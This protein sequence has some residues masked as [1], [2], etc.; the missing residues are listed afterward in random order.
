M[1]SRV[2][3]GVAAVSLATVP[4][5]AHA[6]AEPLSI[7]PAIERA[8]AAPGDSQLAGRSWLPPILFA[9][10]VLGG[11]LTATGVIFDDD[12]DSP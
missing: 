3:A 5:L 7:Q 9:A 4:T 10:I 1:F 8:G 6:A 11:I 2:F 12:P